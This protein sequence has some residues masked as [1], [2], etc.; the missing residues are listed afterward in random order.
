M[1]KAQHGGSTADVAIKGGEGERRGIG[2]GEAQAG[3]RD[4]EQDQCGGQ[5][6]PSE[7]G[8]DQ[9]QQRGRAFHQEGAAEDLGARKFSQQENVDLIAADEAD[10]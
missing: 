5:A 3:Q 10:G 2:E 1:Q 4:E 8:S 7:I 9:E 6:E